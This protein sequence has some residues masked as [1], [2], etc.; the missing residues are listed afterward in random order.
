MLFLLLFFQAQKNKK[1]QSSLLSYFSSGPASKKKRLEDE[2][3]DALEHEPE[4]E[5]EDVLSSSSPRSTATTKDNTPADEVQSCSSCSTDELTIGLIN[6]RDRGPGLAKACFREGSFQPQ[7]LNF[8][9][10]DGRKF[11]PE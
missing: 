6:E 5:V 11:R 3:P 8:S 2:L 1:G 7:D 4:L 10:T 9:K